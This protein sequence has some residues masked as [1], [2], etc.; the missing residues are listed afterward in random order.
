MQEEFKM[1]VFSRALLTAVFVGIM[2]TVLTLIYYVYFVETLK[3]PLADYFNVSTL[4]FSVNLVF[5][6]IGFIYYAFV[7]SS[8]KGEL[9]YIIVF[10]LLTIFGVWKAEGAHRVSDHLVNIQFR[11]LLAGI[12]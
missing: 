9:S 7:S 11:N 6:V 8:K 10:I 5:F 4:I 3:F 12:I 2:S 1:P